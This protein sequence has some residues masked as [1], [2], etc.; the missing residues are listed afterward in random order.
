MNPRETAPPSGPLATFIRFFLEQKL[1]AF[2]VLAAIILWGVAVAPFDWNLGGF[3][4][5]PVPV[6]AIP[7][8][9]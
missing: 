5:D 9:G 2:L 4:R 8:L 6:D 1:V 3:P 7:N